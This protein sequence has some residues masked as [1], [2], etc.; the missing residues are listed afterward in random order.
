MPTPEHSL[1]AISVLRVT[2]ICKYMPVYNC[3]TAKSQDWRN[4]LCLT[5]LPLC[6]TICLDFITKLEKILLLLNMQVVP[7]LPIDTYLSLSLKN[8]TLMLKTDSQKQGN[9]HC[10]DSLKFMALGSAD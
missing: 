1:L 8:P 3:S 4:Y 10:K 5:D 9:S 2:A 6:L 7:W